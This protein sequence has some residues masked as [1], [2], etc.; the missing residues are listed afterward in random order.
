[1]T[2]SYKRIRRLL[3]EYDEQE[4]KTFMPKAAGHPHPSEQGFE[5]GVDPDD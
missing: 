1:M 3:R 4:T 2:N 5:R